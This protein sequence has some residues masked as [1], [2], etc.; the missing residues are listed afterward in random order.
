[1]LVGDI[2]EAGGRRFIVLEVIAEGSLKGL[3]KVRFEC[4]PG[5]WFGV[6]GYVSAKQVR[7]IDG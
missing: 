1:M 5:S 4:K 7:K 2:G 3:L 6:V